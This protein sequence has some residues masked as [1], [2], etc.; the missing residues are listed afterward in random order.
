MRTALGLVTAIT[1]V[2][3]TAVPASAAAPIQ[4]TLPAP[5]GHERLGSV[6]LH[7]VDQNRQDPWGGTGRRELMVTV[8]YPARDTER[9]PLAPWLPTNT[10]EAFRAAVA[11]ALDV[12][13]S[14]VRFPVGRSHSGAPARPG[15]HP[16]LLY[17][18][19]YGMERG[20]G[21]SQV[22][23]LASRGY[24]VVSID[25]PGDAGA[26]QFP[27]G[28]LEPSQQP[29]MPTDPAQQ[30]Q[31]IGKALDVRVADTRFVLDQLAVLA[32]GDNPDA[33]RRPLPRGLGR[34]L[35][36]SHPAMFGHSLGGAT[37][38][39]VMT[40]DRRVAAGV[41]LDGTLFGSV[42]DSGLDRPFLLMGAGTHGRGDDPT[43]ASFWSH[44]TG[45]HRELSLPAGAHMGYTDLQQVVAQ[46]VRAKVIPAE[47]AVPP[48]GTVDA[49]RSTSA[50]RAYLDAFFDLQVRH[51]DSGLLD[52]PSSRYPEIE[53]IP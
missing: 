30:K 1:A 44:T 32:R 14:A 7:L 27:D 18:P 17:S 43:W 10:T 13:L 3:A 38:A 37:A 34:A 39:Q 53:F 23:E 52:G 20:L 29:P 48:I 45:W 26:V 15:E 24:V 12:D 2:L 40:E 33:E 51:C 22:E 31:V 46:L 9:Y 11:K 28:H 19:G 25:H 50:Q 47:K 35:D 8:T 41:D 4:T 16:V 36:L 6:E 42:A 21:A 5:T 49:D